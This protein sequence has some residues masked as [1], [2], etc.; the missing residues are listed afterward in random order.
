MLLMPI[1]LEN[2]LMN[3]L[4]FLLAISLNF[5]VLEY[6]INAGSFCLVNNANCLILIC[7]SGVANF[8]D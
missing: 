4:G 1:F 3:I 5:F 6:L 8:V 2:G 7:G